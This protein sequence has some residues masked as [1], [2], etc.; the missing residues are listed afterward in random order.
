[1]TCRRARTIFFGCYEAKHA[2]TDD[3]EPAPN[4]FPRSL[5]QVACV[6]GVERTYARRSQRL[7]RYAV[8]LPSGV[9]EPACSAHRGL[10]VHTPCMA[11]T[12]RVRC[13]ASA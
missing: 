7:V 2:M 4:D 12:A 9:V 1:M 5:E 10:A 11:C 3:C 6:R 13:C 8:R